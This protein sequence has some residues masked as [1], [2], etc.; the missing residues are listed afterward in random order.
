MMLE[1]TPG[2]GEGENG[3]TNGTETETVTETERTETEIVLDTERT[4]PD[5]RR[6]P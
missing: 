1:T 6:Q 4:E 5:R 2:S 3:A